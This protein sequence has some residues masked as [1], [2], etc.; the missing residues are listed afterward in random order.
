MILRAADCGNIP[1]H[2]VVYPTSP[3]APDGELHIVANVAVVDKAKVSQ[4]Y[5]DVRCGG[6][7]VVPDFGRGQAGDT[8]EPFDYPR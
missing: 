4:G 7:V 5:Q 8:A 2:P 6:L 1:R 3:E